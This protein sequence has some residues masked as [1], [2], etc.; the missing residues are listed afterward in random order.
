[1]V[2]AHRLLGGFKHKTVISEYRE[3]APLGST[4]LQRICHELLMKLWTQDKEQ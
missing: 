2:E 1:M 3:E 4:I